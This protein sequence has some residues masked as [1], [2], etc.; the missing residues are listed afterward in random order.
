MG[1]SLSELAN[2]YD[3]TKSLPSPTPEFRDDALVFLLKA[4]FMEMKK[5]GS[6]H[7]HYPE[8]VIGKWAELLLANQISFPNLGLAE[9]N[10]EK[11][12]QRAKQLTKPYIPLEILNLD[13]KGTMLFISEWGRHT[14]QESAY[15]TIFKNNLLNA[16][17]L[18]ALLLLQG[19]ELQDNLEFDEHIDVKRILLD[20]RKQI[21]VLHPYF[22]SDHLL[23]ETQVNSS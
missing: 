22:L 18:F 23:K 10:L 20:H 2:R 7:R 14:L 11:L 21:V 9:D 8:P 6:L 19:I 17:A 12:S 3:P 16:K 4:S 5:N 15:E 1:N 13:S